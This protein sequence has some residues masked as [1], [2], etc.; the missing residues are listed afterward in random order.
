MGASLKTSGF[1]F[2]DLD[3]VVAHYVSEDLPRSFEVVNISPY[4]DASEPFL[5]GFQ[6]ENVGF[7][8]Q[9]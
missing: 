7:V 4:L 8:M 1:D 6:S 9:N 5:F 3:K 2:E